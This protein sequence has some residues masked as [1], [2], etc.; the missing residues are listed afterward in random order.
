M[1]VDTLPPTPPSKIPSV[2]YMDGGELV[3]VSWN[4]A[5]FL[6]NKA[7]GVQKRSKIAKAHLIGRIARSL[8]LMSNVSLK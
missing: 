3:D 8:G 6:C 2:A 7:K 1:I 5:K 4:V